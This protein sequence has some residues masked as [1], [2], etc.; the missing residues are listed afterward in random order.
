MGGGIW[1]GEGGCE[2]RGGMGGGDD[3]TRPVNPK[4]LIIR[5]LEIH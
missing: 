4:K 2:Q 3:C 1:G 5:F